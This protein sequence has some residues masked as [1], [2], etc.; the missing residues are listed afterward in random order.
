MDTDM[1]IG[2]LLIA[3]GEQYWPFVKPFLESARKFF[4]EG[5]FDA[6]LWTD[7][8]ESYDV[9][10][11]FE[12]E[13][14]PRPLPSLLRYHYFTA[15]E[16]TLSGYHCFFAD[17][18]MRFVA[19]VGEEILGDL[20]ATLHPGYVFKPDYYSP[21]EP[22]PKSAA[23][24]PYP[25]N[26]YCGGFQGGKKYIEA[27]RTLKEMVDK[28]FSIGYRAIWSDESHWNRYLIDNP[29]DKILSPSYCYPET[30]VQYY[31]SKWPEDYQPKVLALTK[32]FDLN[33]EGGKWVS[34]WLK[35]NEK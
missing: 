8:N 28:D 33:K 11:V 4:F 5:K 35:E 6:F 24:V 1:K 17:I 26:Y 27:C 22:N 30:F 7:S 29:P 25:K 14:A 32:L 31:K 23:Y 15:E 9:E 12:V 20:T 3:S 16:K 21:F 18:D 13:H 19:P 10:Q 2:L 34:N